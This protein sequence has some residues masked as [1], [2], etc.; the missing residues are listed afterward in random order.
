MMEEILRGLVEQQLLEKFTTEWFGKL[1]FTIFPAIFT[2]LGFSFKDIFKVFK[3]NKNRRACKY[4]LLNKVNDD[5]FESYIKKFAILLFEMFIIIINVLVICG[6]IEIFVLFA[7]I[8]GGAIN[9]KTSVVILTLIIA[10][11]L[12]VVAFVGKNRHARLLKNA[13]LMVFLLSEGILTTM[14]TTLLAKKVEICLITL[15]IFSILF[16]FSLIFTVHK[17]EIY[18]KHNYCVVKIVRAVRYIMLAVDTF[19]YFTELRFIENNIT[20]AIWIVL[21][22]F[23]Y[24][25]IV[26]HD[27]VNRVNVTLHTKSGE[28][29][30]KD[31]IMQYEEDKIGYRLLDGKKEIVDNDEVEKITYQRRHLIFKENVTKKKVECKLRSGKVFQYQS[32]VLVRD[33]WVEF[34]R[35]EKGIREILLMKTRDIE[36][37][38]EEKY[39]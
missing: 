28:L 6:V 21:C 26:A 1:L 15:S 29:V 7:N 27:D 20:V 25:W 10:V 12:I 8:R 3:L 35:N 37:I 38:T 9:D 30:T 22:C 17:C 39:Q 23:E 24:I 11:I 32:Y 14:W 5:S 4:V 13:K 16:I 33:S 2:C 18:K 19:I 36:K 31:K 34:A